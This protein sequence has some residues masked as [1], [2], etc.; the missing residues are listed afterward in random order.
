M[1]ALLLLL[2]LHVL[3]VSHYMHQN[4]LSGSVQRLSFGPAKGAAKRLC[5]VFH[6]MHCGD[7]CTAATAC[8]YMCV[9]QSVEDAV[10]ATAT[11]R[12]TGSLQPARKKVRTDHAS[13]RSKLIAKQA[14]LS[15]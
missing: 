3:Y 2:L 10:A 12:L 7:A 5:P 11:R 9:H 6:S 4:R 8:M 15:H 1:H 14:S 13:N